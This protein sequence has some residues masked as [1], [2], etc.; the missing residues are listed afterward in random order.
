[1]N[2]KKNWFIFFCIILAPIFSNY[3]FIGDFSVGDLLVLISI[4]YILINLQFTFIDVVAV[5]VLFFLVLASY[6]LVGGL[7]V[8]A[9][10]YRA[11]FYYFI[12]NLILCGFKYDDSLEFFE[13]YSKVCYVLS[14]ALIMQWLLYV[15]INTSIPLQLPIE[16]YEPDTLNVIDH[17]FRS[18]GLFREPS[19]FALFVI[20]YMF[21]S[22][23]KRKFLGFTFVASAGIISTSS[24][25]FFTIIFASSHAVY[26]GSGLFTRLF[27]IPAG[28]L[29]L[30][31][32][33]F[34]I[35]DGYIFVDR[36]REI[37][38]DGGTLNERFLPFLNIINYYP[39]LP[40][41]EVIDYYRSSGFW[42]NS[43]SSLIV[44]FGISG[45][46]LLIYN[47]SRLGLIYCLLILMLIFSTHIMSSVFGL[48]IVLCFI[49]LKNNLKFKYN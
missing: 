33:L 3:K 14:F 27:L 25:V 31:V 30:M 29:L 21:F 39:F 15:F 22:I 9:G 35:P 17:V 26:Q 43:A 19:Y 28:F 10:F 48:F 40:Y 11:V 20:P 8:Y 5:I 46:L 49:L 42:F 24:L 12:V 47:L 37:F 38:I 44:Y 1:M 36:I 41:G 4:P 7:D 16:T 34:F 18:G 6:L 32:I 45:L 23:N 2:L 13:I